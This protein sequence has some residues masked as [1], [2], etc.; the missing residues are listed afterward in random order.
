MVQQ[1][2]PALVVDR[3]FVCLVFQD[4]YQRVFLVRNYLFLNMCASCSWTSFPVLLLF[5]GRELVGNDVKGALCISTSIPSMSRTIYGHHQRFLDTYYNPFKGQ[6]TNKPTNRSRRRPLNRP[7]TV[8]NKWMNEKVHECVAVKFPC[9]S[10]WLMWCAIFEPIGKR[11]ST[12]LHQWR[13]SSPSEAILNLFPFKVTISR[14][15]ERCVTRM[16]TTG[17]QEG[18]MTSS[19]LVARDWGQRKSKM[20]W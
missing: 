9:F 15:T 14:A 6:D 16:A 19:M 10:D 20:L 18:W 12:L 7:I 13:D 4:L 11:N 5:Q 17:S 1:L 3:I 8:Q 2:S